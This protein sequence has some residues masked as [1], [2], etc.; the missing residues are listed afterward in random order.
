L[1]I[2]R[3]FVEP[4]KPGIEG[5]DAKLGESLRLMDSRRLLP[6]MMPSLS[7]AIWEASVRGYSLI[8]RLNR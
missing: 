8:L 2:D 1:V 5:I 3:Q 7:F 6:T 4:D